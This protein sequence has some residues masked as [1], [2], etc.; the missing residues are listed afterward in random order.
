MVPVTEEAEHHI[1]VVYSGLLVGLKT[2]VQ[3]VVSL[4]MCC[5]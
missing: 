2:L 5:C 1:A 4:W 3:W